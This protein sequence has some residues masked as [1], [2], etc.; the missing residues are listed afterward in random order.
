MGWLSVGVG[1]VRV[2]TRGASVG[3]AGVRVGGSWKRR[4][5]VTG[6]RVD[7][8]IPQLLEHVHVTNDAG[9]DRGGRVQFPYAKR[10]R[11][12]R[13]FRV[14]ESENGILVLRDKRDEM[15]AAMRAGFANIPPEEAYLASMCIGE[16]TA[17]SFGSWTDCVAEDGARYAT[18]LA[19][20]TLN[21][22]ENVDTTFYVIADTP[23][24]V[25]CCPFEAERRDT[26]ERADILDRIDRLISEIDSFGPKLVNSLKPSAW[27]LEVLRNDLPHRDIPTLLEAEKELSHLRTSIV[28]TQLPPSELSTLRARLQHASPPQGDST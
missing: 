10:S 15:G 22:R 14:V 27:L 25:V 21:W 3:A 11:K 1:P 16:I 6:G 20:V 9:D 17:A 26:G 2:S 8:T 19:R 18:A 12:Q 13:F 7:V 4:G 24:D 28:P 5:G 23:A